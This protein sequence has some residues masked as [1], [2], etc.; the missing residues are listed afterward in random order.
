LV[1]TVSLALLRPQIH[2]E[3]VNNLI[4]NYEDFLL[5]LRTEG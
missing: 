1:V 4:S 2:V 5:D 3:L